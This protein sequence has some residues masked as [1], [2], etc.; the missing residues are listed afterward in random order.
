MTKLYAFNESMFPADQIPINEQ[1]IV[2]TPIF[3]WRSKLKVGLVK[4]AWA[5]DI[6]IKWKSVLR[7]LE[8]EI[9]PGQKVWALEMGAH[10]HPHTYNIK[11]MW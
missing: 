3:V 5:R 8:I 10:E 6:L 1:V 4:N 9:R 2:I 11:T 7:W